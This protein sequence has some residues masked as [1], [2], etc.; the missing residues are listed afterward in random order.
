MVIN[1]IEKLRKEIDEVDEEILK[2]LSKRKNLVREIAKLKKSMNLPVMDAER[3]KKVLDNLKNKAK[4][5][6]L[7][8]KFVESIYK[9]VLKN[10][11]EEQKRNG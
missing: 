1:L 8:K 3:E 5:K 9:I 4:E 11:R 10:S 6:R 7:N 2:N